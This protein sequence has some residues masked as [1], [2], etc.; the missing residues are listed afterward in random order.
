MR[1]RARVTEGI[2]ADSLCA[3]YGWWESCPELGLP[4]YA[5]DRYN[6]N[7]L[8]DDARFDPTSG[9]NAMRGYPCAIALDTPAPVTATLAGDSP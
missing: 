7:A 6:Y 5:I 9:S 8:I 2:A 4:G 3:Q 1:A